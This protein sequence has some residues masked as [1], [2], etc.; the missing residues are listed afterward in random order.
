MSGGA[1]QPS[2]AAS[3]V[4]ASA[5]PSDGSLLRGLVGDRGDYRVEE[6]E[7]DSG[8]ELSELESREGE[9]E[10]QEEWEGKGCGRPNFKRATTGTRQQQSTQEFS[11][12]GGDNIFYTPGKPVMG[13][14]LARSLTPAASSE[15]EG[16]TV[17]TLN[18]AKSSGEGRG[19]LD[20]GADE[21]V[22]EVA[23][24]VEMADAE[25]REAR[26]AVKLLATEGIER[27]MLAKANWDIKQWTDLAQLME[28]RRVEI[29]EIKKAVEGIAVLAAGGPTLHPRAGPAAVEPEAMEGV[30]ATRQ[31]EIKDEV[32]E[33]SDME[34]VEREGLFGSK[35]APALGEPVS[36]MP[37]GPT[38]EEKKKKGKEKGKGKAVQIAA[39]PA[40]GRAARQQK[41]QAAV[42][43]ANTGKP[44]QPVAPIR[45]I[46]KRPEAAE[47]EKKEMEKKREEE[48]A[49]KE[50]EKVGKKEKEKAAAVKRCVTL[51]HYHGSAWILVEVRTEMRTR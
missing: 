42:D 45:S 34:G 25:E 43:M 27:D 26:L 46:L 4:T 32:E 18:S 38:T 37:P 9:M 49:R 17:E 13:G 35:H 2:K 40:M 21:W 15:Q 19:K 10:V 29:G 33:W 51:E 41:R 1:I 30:V 48:A 44:E 3:M 11:W 31:K 6:M 22:K 28:R 50:V 23:N 24:E 8:S 5:G 47:A 12:R 14:A 36:S 20:V 39:S 16:G 7:E